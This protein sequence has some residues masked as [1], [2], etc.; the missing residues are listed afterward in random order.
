MY[1]KV[2]D[3]V[4]KVLYKVFRGR[5]KVVV[6]ALN[7][8]RTSKVLMGNI[9]LIVISMLSIFM[10]TSIGTSMKESSSWSISRDGF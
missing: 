9:T 4:T 1:P 6:F 7:N 3:L 2:I 10:I 5:S 8:L